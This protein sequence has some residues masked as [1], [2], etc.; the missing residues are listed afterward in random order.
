MAD[1][2][3]L[4]SAVRVLAIAKYMKLSN[5]LFQAFCAVGW[6]LSRGRHV[7]VARAVSLHRDTWKEP[8]IKSLAVFDGQ[9][10][11]VTID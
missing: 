7:I 11:M 10:K 6:I 2:A 8:L 1:G 4:F 5:I 9:D 3:A